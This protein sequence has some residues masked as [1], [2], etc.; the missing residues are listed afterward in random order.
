MENNC[1]Q[2]AQL[3][4]RTSISLS[5]CKIQGVSHKGG[6]E[7]CKNQI[8]EDQRESTRPV[9][10][11]LTAAVVAYTKPAQD[12]AGKHSDMEWEPIPVPEEL[13]TCNGLLRKESP[14]VIR[15]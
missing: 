12:Q 1:H 6:E 3:Q 2:S 9:Y 4:K 5:L 11:E 14:F 10:W 13:W 15:V 8:R 7:N